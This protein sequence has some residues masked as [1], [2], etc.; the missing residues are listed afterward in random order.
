MKLS[1]VIPAYNESQNIE[2]VILS[3]NQHA[4]DHIPREIIIVDHESTDD[5]AELARSAGATVIVSSASTVAAN[6]NI[7]AARSSGNILVFLD[8]DVLLSKE[9]A[10]NIIDTI[11]QIVSGRRMLTGSWVCVSRNPSLLEKW[12][13]R[14]LEQAAVKSHMN[15]GHMIIAKHLFD[16]MNGFDARYETG[17]DYEFSSRAKKAGIE[18]ID[19]KKLIAYHEGN[20]RTLVEFIKREYWHGRGDAVS[21]KAILESKVAMLAI[22][23]ALLHVLLLISSFYSSIAAFALIGTILLVT[24]I[25]AWAKFSKEPFHVIAFNCMIYYAYF[26]ARVVSM[27]SALFDRGIKKRSR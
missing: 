10:Y 19:N 3:I 14:P 12:W 22:A 17:E 25:P 8:A 5:T 16:E 2:Q 24:F 7:G 27:A 6:R 11:E 1:F 26:W 21:L 4:P 23:F 9:W 18:I 15:T 13:F 20:P